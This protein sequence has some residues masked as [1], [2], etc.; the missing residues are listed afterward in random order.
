MKRFKEICFWEKELGVV[1]NKGLV[2]INK[3][4]KVVAERGNRREQ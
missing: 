3:N 2:I 4:K 1:K